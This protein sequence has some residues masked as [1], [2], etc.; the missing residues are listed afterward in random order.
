MYMRE[1]PHNQVSDRM[2]GKLHKITSVSL[3]CTFIKKEC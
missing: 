2:E 1:I 3:L